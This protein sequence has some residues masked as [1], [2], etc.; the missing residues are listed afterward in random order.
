MTVACISHLVP[1][2]TPNCGGNKY[3]QGEKQT[4]SNYSLQ[5]KSLFLKL[6]YFEKY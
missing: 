3:Q 2:V 4:I 1:P 5:L 6:E